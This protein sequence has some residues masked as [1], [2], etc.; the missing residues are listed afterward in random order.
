M[1]V[2]AL[3]AL[4]RDLFGADSTS[5]GGDIGPGGGGVI[6]PDTPIDPDAPSRRH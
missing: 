1:T 2:L 4:L 6:P 3:L 5:H